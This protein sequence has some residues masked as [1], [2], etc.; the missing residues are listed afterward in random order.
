MMLAMPPEVPKS[1]FRTIGEGTFWTSSSTFVVKAIGLATIFI[2]LRQLGVGEYG[3]L[4]LVLSIT[5][6]LSIFFLP[7]L[8]SIVTADMG[9]EKG[10][11]NLSSARNILVAF[12]T[13]QFICATVAWFL[14]F[15]GARFFASLYNIPPHYVEVVA[16]LFLIGPIRSAYSILFRVNLRFFLLSTLTVIEEGCKLAVLVILFFVTE[17]GVFKML[18]VILGS[19]VSALFILAPAFIRSWRSLQGGADVPM[20]WWG[21]LR[22]HGKWG[23][24]ATYV[25]NV[26]KSGRLWL[27]QRF[28]GAEAVGIYS[29][30]SGLMGHTAALA[31]LYAV[32]TPMLPQFVHDQARFKR[33]VNKAIQYQ[34][35]AYMFIGIFAFFLF[36]PVLGWFFPAYVAAFPLFQVMLLTLFPA[37]VIIIVNPVFAAFKLQKSLFVSM[38]IRSA[39]TIVLTYVGVILFGI[40]G[41]VF[42]ALVTSVLQTIERVWTLRRH[43]PGLIINPVHFFRFD[44]D[45][46][47]ILGKARTVISRLF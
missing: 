16:F 11:G 13:L 9:V 28:L 10:R 37:A 5:T 23:V 19:Q 27:I 32:I 24:F 20:P 8:E 34:M 43:V 15:F 31:P 2:M 21:L 45:D 17:L 40:W 12:M 47:L 1:V 44:E 30:A 41:V 29:V 25:G 35:L 42:E 36:P 3:V 7:G 6:L 4:E 33:L 46:R 26:G 22:G 38:S 18:F 39:M 14:V